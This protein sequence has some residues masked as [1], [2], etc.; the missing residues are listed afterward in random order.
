MHPKD[1]G[2]PTKRYVSTKTRI[3]RTKFFFPLREIV[4]TATHTL[5]RVRIG[6]I[7]PHT[8]EN[9]PKKN[10]ILAAQWHTVGP[11][12]TNSATS[13]PKIVRTAT[14]TSAVGPKLSGL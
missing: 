12:P 7:L 2:K 9:N 1:P 3:V 4:Q 10:A 11:P 5:T 6:R 14:Q 8:Y 13:P